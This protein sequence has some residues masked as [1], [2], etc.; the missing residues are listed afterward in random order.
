MKK[1]RVHLIGVGGSGM[2]AIARLLLEMGYSVSGSDQ[3]D[4]PLLND[5]RSQ[6][7]RISIG[8]SPENIKNVDFVIRSSAIQD[9]NPEVISALQ[10]GIPV[11]K[12]SDFLGS[13]LKD[14]RC[15]AVAGTHGKTS[16]TA[17]L[18]WTLFSL[19]QEPSFIVGGILRNLGLNAKA[20]IGDC[21]V[22]EADEYDRMFLGL[23]PE[24]EIITNVEHDHPDI[25]PTSSDFQKAFIDFINLLPSHG[26]LVVC[27]QD[28]GSRHLLSYALEQKLDCHPYGIIDKTGQDSSNEFMS[29]YATN[30]L[31][32]L[33]GGYSFEAN[34][35][36]QTCHV[37][38]QVPGKY[39][40]QNC[41]A[42]LTVISILELSLEKACKALNE[43]IGVGRRFEIRS[44]AS[45]ITVVDDYAH[46][47]TEIRNTLAA[48]RSRFSKRKLWVV[49]QP[50]TYT[51][52]RLFQSDFAKSFKDADHVIVT[53]VYA[54]RESPQDYSSKRVVDEMSHPSA[55]WIPDFGLIIDHLMKKMLPGDVLMV[56]SAGDADA[57]SS[58]VIKQFT[59]K[60][61]ANA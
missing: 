36:G 19:G 31:V 42:V 38:L 55:L 51:R 18:A 12:R 16:T 8:H 45:G 57:I 54:S 49:W 58:Q 27:A 46:H 40:V 21:F 23:T 9:G 14:K 53:E 33:K 60:E 28:P 52:T 43:F 2:S 10:S 56:F 5:L 15:I 32:N 41:L 48:A 17:M 34:V 25:F 39:N 3:F 1:E 11:K 35:N 22:I 59:K 4:S 30:L 61:M 26:K 7:A 47:P 6:G 24:I 29:S 50:H 37:D 44:E 20:G 13:L